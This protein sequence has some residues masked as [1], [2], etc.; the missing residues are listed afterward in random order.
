VTDKMTEADRK[1]LEGFAVRREAER[2]FTEHNRANGAL[3]PFGLGWLSP[4]AK[5]PWLEKARASLASRAAPP[6]SP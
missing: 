1:Y 5:Q 3:M 6:V 4:V 2:L